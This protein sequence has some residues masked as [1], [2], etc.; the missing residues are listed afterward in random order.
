MKVQ[1]PFDDKLKT[2][3]GRAPGEVLE[4]AVYVTDTLDLCW[5]AAQAV[6]ED[7]ATSADAMAIFRMIH[8]RI[9]NLRDRQDS[10]S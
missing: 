2:Y 8:E 6:F 1:N 10:P 3:Q 9:E 5:A 7:R 4:A